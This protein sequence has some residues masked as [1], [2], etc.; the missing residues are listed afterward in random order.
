MMMRR[1]QS[2][3]DRTLSSRKKN[4]A[5]IDDSSFSEQEKIPV[6]SST[7]R[8]SQWVEQNSEESCCVDGKK[9]QR[10]NVRPNSSVA[11]LSVV[12]RMPMKS[13]YTNVRSM[14][15][16]QGWYQYAKRHKK[17]RGSRFYLFI[18]PGDLHLLLYMAKSSTRS[19]V[20]K[21]SWSSS[22]KG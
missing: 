19:D 5:T 1:L 11:P 3:L 20:E 13:I 12:G 8:A 15:L 10:H 4:L 16:V 14:V 22:P 2:S 21:S 18:L 17:S 7:P 6:P 9:F